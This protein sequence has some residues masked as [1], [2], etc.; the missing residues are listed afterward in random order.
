VFIF[1]LSDV[2]D[3]TEI[4]FKASYQTVFD[5]N[6]INMSIF[7]HSNCQIVGDVAVN[8]AS[9]SKSAQILALSTYSIDEHDKE[10]NKVLF[11][12]NEVFSWHAILAFFISSKG[13]LIPQSEI[14]SE[15][16]A[17]LFDWHPNE[18]LLAVG[19]ADGNT[20]FLYAL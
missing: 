18:K 16:E 19:W 14:E 5:L 11:V 3:E 20:Y 6:F 13:E 10:T 7:V 2:C 9:W 15:F 4:C 1:F 17:T 8:H 12:N